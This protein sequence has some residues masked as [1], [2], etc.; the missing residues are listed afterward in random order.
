[1]HRQ[2]WASVGQ[3]REEHTKSSNILHITIGTLWETKVFG[4]RGKYG[5]KAETTMADRP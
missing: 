4:F 2:L 3:A 1:M 5:C